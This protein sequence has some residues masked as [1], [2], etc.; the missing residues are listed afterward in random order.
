MQPPVEN[1]IPAGTGAGLVAS[2]APDPCAHVPGDEA[3]FASGRR[4]WPTD[5]VIDAP[6]SRSIYLGATSWPALERILREHLRVKHVGP[7][8]DKPPLLWAETDGPATPGRLRVDLRILQSR[9]ITAATQTT[10][11]G[12]TQHTYEPTGLS[13]DIT[14]E[15]CPSPA[16]WSQSEPARRITIRPDGRTVET[17]HTAMNH[18]NTTE[19][20][21]NSPPVMPRCTASPN[22]EA[23]TSRSGPHRRAA[24]SPCTTS[25]AASS[26]PTSTFPSTPTSWAKSD[27]SS[28]KLP[29]PSS[30]SE[31]ASAGAVHPDPGRSPIE[32]FVDP[33]RFC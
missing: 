11:G 14:I 22:K 27:P 3:L 13:R 24:A 4:D 10:P 2:V 12:C 33:D 16:R 23:S 7:R 9:R 20:P 5:I 29:T 15:T 31:P 32:F 25:K 6:S 21:S 26:L 8:G 19:K 17:A 18:T 1:D 28:S 30:R